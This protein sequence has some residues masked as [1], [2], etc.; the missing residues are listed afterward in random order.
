MS[1]A[2]RYG[3][4]STVFMWVVAFTFVSP[5]VSWWITLILGMSVLAWPRKPDM[6]TSI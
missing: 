5:L 3:G 4:W 1:F 2:E 6:D